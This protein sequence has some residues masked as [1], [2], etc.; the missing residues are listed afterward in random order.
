MSAPTAAK[1]MVKEKGAPK[2][3]GRP[4]NYDLGNGIYR[5]SRTRMYHKKQLFKFIGKKVASKKSDVKNAQFVEKPIGGEKNGGK[6]VVRTTRRR[7]YYA[8]QDKIPRRNSRG[9]CY[10]QHKRNLRSS[11]QPGA[12]LI[13]LAGPHKGKRVI[14]LK[15]LHSGMLLVTGP[16][17]INGCPTR[18]THPNYVIA[19][20][21][22][23]ELGDFKLEDSINDEYFRRERKR[24]PK[25]EEGDIFATKKAGYKP[26]ETR[27]TDQKA[28]DGKVIEAI[29]RS[30]EKKLLFAYLATMFGLRSSQYPHRMKF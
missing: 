1:A 28:V 10:S 9:R 17:K 25:K 3:P 30:P 22:R 16:F 19:T 13:L 21:T 6:R 14:L 7:A 26:T 18:R 23:V 5:F 4:R 29:K 11:L 20:Q 24:R 27:K 2:K 15:R 12:I 8:T